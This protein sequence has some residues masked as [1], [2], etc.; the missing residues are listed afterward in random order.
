MTAHLIEQFLAACGVHS[1]LPLQVSCP[2]W[3]GPVV[4]TFHQPF[5]V[6]GRDPRADLCLNAPE[7]SP[8]HAYLQVIA[9]TVYCVDLQSETGTHWPGGAA[10]A[11]WLDGARPIQIG[12]FAVALA[13]DELQDP[14]AFGPPW[15]WSPLMSRSPQASRIPGITLELVN[16]ADRQGPRRLNR[17]LALVGSAPGCNVRLASSTVS[18]FH[19]A[20]LRTP[21]GLWAVDLL[22]RDGIAVNGTPLRYALIQDGDELRIGKFRL[23]VRTEEAG[24]APVAVGAAPNGTAEHPVERPRVVAGRETP[25]DLAAVSIQELTLVPREHSALLPL[26]QQFHLMQ[27]QLFDQF[28]QTMLMVV[29]MF[30]ALHREQTE[31]VRKD[32]ERVHTLTRELQAL[33]AELRGQKIANGTAAPE[34]PRD[35]PRA[36]ADNGT[37]AAPPL[38]RP[39]STE[40]KPPAPDETIH[41]WLTDRIASLQ[42]E[43]QSQWQ[44]I[45]RILGKK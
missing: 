23:R 28:Q 37:P 4:R 6:I 31:L 12:P 32:L 40:E 33:Q 45:F 16:T 22:G 34:P 11:G 2:S 35:K 8:C 3:K 18:R 9:G 21:A 43:R 29:Q 5:V 14:D 42:Q 19:C 41:A 17:L 13:V 1:P 38:R 20:L 7:V 44:K 39:A 36:A 10:R 24:A 27:Q 25:A 26:V 15:D 30:G